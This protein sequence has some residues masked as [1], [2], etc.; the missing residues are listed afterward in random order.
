MSNCGASVVTHCHTVFVPLCPEPRWACSPCGRASS[1]PQLAD[2]RQK[3]KSGLEEGFLMKSRVTNQSSLLTLLVQVS[4]KDLY[5]SDA[6]Q[7]RCC[8]RVW[9]WFWDSSSSPSTGAAPHVPRTPN[10][11][12][13]AFPT[14]TD[15]A[16]QALQAVANPA[17]LPAQL[18]HCHGG[19]AATPHPLTAFVTQPHT[20]RS[21]NCCSS[22]SAL[23]FRVGK[24]QHFWVS[25]FLNEEGLASCEHPVVYG[26]GIS[27][28]G[29]FMG[30]CSDRMKG[31]ALNWK[32]VG[33]D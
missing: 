5:V 25:F 17:C 15:C 6:A 33:L 7:H 13:T 30:A 12:A 11:A 2:R 29:F 27:S 24:K 32:K 20:D 28:L 8:S 3:F 18:C 9:A 21:P 23:P 10:T 4:R 22:P 1:S 19:R 31:M 16:H 14:H 26:A